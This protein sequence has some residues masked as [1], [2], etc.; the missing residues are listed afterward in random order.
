[1][2]T[3]SQ[4]PLVLLLAVL[5]VQIDLVASFLPRHVPQRQLQLLQEAKYPWEGPLR[6][7]EMQKVAKE[8]TL[9]QIHCR[10]TAGLDMKKDVLP[11]VEK[12]VRSFPFAAVL[13]VQPLKYLPTDDGV[14][15]TFLRKKTKEKGSMDGGLRFF[16]LPNTSDKNGDDLEIVVK[17]NSEGQTV[18]KI[19]SEKLVVL[20][21]VKSFTGKDEEGKELTANDPP[22]KELVKVESV[23]HKWMDV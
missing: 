7:E 11:K 10:P 21:F 9:L 8:E 14:A 13:P 6:N 23:F 1:M 5:F 22:T 17:R 19:F 2:S 3:S 4:I 15:V 18:G 16:V 12:Y 20:A